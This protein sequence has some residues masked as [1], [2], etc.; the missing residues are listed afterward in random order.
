MVIKPVL[1]PPLPP[2]AA[3]ASRQLRVGAEAPFKIALLVLCASK[4]RGG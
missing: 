1:P 4:R 2:P 3:L